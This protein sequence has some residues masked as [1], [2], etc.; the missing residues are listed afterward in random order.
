MQQ[1]GNVSL[2]ILLAT[3][4]SI[5][6]LRAS[7]VPRPRLITKL[8]QAITH[9]LT[10]ISAPAGS[11]KTTILSEWIA[12][13]P[14]LPVAWLSL[15]KGD[16]DLVRFWH[17]CIAALRKFQPDLGETA[18][19]LLASLPSSQPPSIEA[20]LITLLN[21][22]AALADDFMLVLDDYHVIA[23]TTIHR[24]LEFLL[25][26][27]PEHVHIVIT[28]RSDP[29]L[30]LSRLRALSEMIEIRATDL[31]FTFEEAT[32]FLQQVMHIQLSPEDISTLEQRTEGWV[33]GL[34]LA[35]LS[36]QGQRD[37]SAFVAS[38]SG[39]DRYV[40]D[41][42]LEEVLQQQPEPVQTFLMETSILNRLTAPLCNALC[43]RRDGQE[44]LE[45][46]ERAN[47]FLVPLDNERRWYRY[48]HLFADLLRYR[49]QQL[50]P[51]R[52]ID[53]HTRAAQWYED[54]GIMIEAV[55]HALTIK[56]FVRAAR[57]ITGMAE[58]MLMR[59]EAMTVFN[60]LNQLPTSLLYSQPELSLAYALAL[61]A[62]SQF[63]AVE[64]YLQYVEDALILANEG[65]RQRDDE[66]QYM[67]G[68][69][70]AARSTVIANLGDYPRAIEL[71]HLALSSLPEQDVLARGMVTLNLGD[72]YLAVGDSSRAELAFTE[73]IAL[74]KK[75]NS[76]L[77]TITTICSL[78]K[79]HALGGRLHKAVEL[80]QQA[81]HLANALSRR[82]GLIVPS[83][84][85]AYIFLG[86]VLLE[87]NDLDTALSHA[88]QGIELCKQWQHL[89]HLIEGYLLL[90]H[91]QLSRG[92]RAEA[93]NA[94]TE[95]EHL[96][97]DETLP[98]ET[99]Q[100]TS[101]YKRAGF[102]D[103][104]AAIKAH[105]WF[106]YDDLDAVAHWIYE[107]ALSIDDHD[108]SFFRGYIILT[109]LLFAQRRYDQALK[110]TERLFAF[111]A[112][113]G[114]FRGTLELL[115]LQALTLNAQGTTARALRSL[116]QALSLAQ[117]AGYIRTFIDYG[118][119]ISG[120]LQRAT[121]HDLVGDYAR[122]LLLACRDSM[123][124]SSSPATT[125]VSPLSEREREI[126]RLLA[127]GMSNRD[128]AEAL[129]I[130]VGTVK[131]YVNSIYGK[132]NVRSRTQAVARARE[133]G[134][135]PS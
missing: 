110:L 120:L 64:P 49:L 19:A 9:K 1:P 29:P 36:L 119:S 78:G 104:M 54:N 129:V 33:T 97:H 48:H 50:V 14:D 93:E 130:T 46:L 11:G 95:L 94:L 88:M 17:Y 51:E 102:L 75:A 58:S 107:R 7:F 8:D 21:D 79:L 26:Y 82:E 65:Y 115:I 85:K 39:C 2:D 121:S 134:I 66:V 60:W 16:N 109:R 71:A 127:T 34:Q 116:I 61:L 12:G 35:A 123:P 108:L 37:S 47:L 23:S 32:A 13:N 5:P 135:L 4:F 43:D 45:K 53:L 113:R 76:H 126:L 133:T 80:Y 30:P 22:L 100:A 74:N 92:N 89:E 132:L 99:V 106:V 83:A 131:W 118:A 112:Q 56:D 10:L 40:L 122:T 6:R 101:N 15:E 86:E 28:C 18:L 44:M 67:K 105:L 124:P 77:V 27:L 62:L 41:Y 38:F 103:E 52:F 111:A 128:I 70:A 87:W 20:V 117:P 42:L 81:L 3:R 24:S 69:I 125:L 68:R 96:V 114:W 55:H 31:R 72:A 91:V 90:I 73:S 84:G 98:S 57:L 59:G 63:D 25:H